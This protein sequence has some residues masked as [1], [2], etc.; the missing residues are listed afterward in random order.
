MVNSITKRKLI[1]PHFL[2]SSKWNKLSLIFCIK[3]Y[4]V[5]IM[6]HDS[7]DMDPLDSRLLKI[8]RIMPFGWVIKHQI[9]WRHSQM[10]MNEWLGESGAM[11]GGCVVEDYIKYLFKHFDWLLVMQGHSIQE[12]SSFFIIFQQ[13]L[14]HS[15]HAREV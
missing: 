5:R 4:L 15:N 2:N 10:M 3:T 9:R 6:W 8:K 14:S 12:H 1:S 11:I 13:L 7:C